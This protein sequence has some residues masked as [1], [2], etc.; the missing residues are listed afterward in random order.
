MDKRDDAREADEHFSRSLR[1]EEEEVAW[2][3]YHDLFLYWLNN[4]AESPQEEG[5]GR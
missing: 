3:S 2:G 5:D 4:Q 1:E